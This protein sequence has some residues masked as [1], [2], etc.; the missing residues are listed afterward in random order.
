MIEKDKLLTL[1][2]KDRILVSSILDK[3][4]QYQ[5]T[6]KGVA[7]NFLNPSEMKLVTN[8]LNYYQIQYSIYDKYHFLEKK[9]IYLESMNHILL[10]IK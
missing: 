8:Y 4:R 10:F 6:Q 1:N 2:K 3:Y 7:S 5:K 9:I